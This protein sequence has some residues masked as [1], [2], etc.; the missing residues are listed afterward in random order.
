MFGEE[1]AGESI[2]SSLVLCF[3]GGDGG[4]RVLMEADYFVVPSELWIQVTILV[5]LPLDS[6]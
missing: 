4:V 6:P 2:L 5:Q 3:L 1:G